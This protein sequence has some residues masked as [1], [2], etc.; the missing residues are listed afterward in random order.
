VDLLR[1]A[2]VVAGIQ[3]LHCK[4]RHVMAPIR[5]PN[6]E[7]QSPMAEPRSVIASTVFE[8]RPL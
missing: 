7:M 2:E 1:V 5:W 4:L 6:A 3:L 8:S